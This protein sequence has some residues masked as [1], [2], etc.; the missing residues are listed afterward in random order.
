MYS[1]KCQANFCCQ[2]AVVLTT[3]YVPTDFQTILIIWNINFFV[4]FLVFPIS[5]T[6]PIVSFIAAAPMQ[7]LLYRVEEDL[8]KWYKSNLSVAKGL[9]NICIIVDN[10]MNP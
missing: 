7:R 5:K 9:G 2:H 3:S 10:R 6:N 1:N 8:S 4:W